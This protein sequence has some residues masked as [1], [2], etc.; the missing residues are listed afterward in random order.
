V[1]RYSTSTE[2]E[3]SSFLHPS[4]KLCKSLHAAASTT[5]SEQNDNNSAQRTFVAGGQ[6]REGVV[7]LVQEFVEPQVDL[8]NNLMSH[9]Y[10]QR[11]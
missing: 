9:N 1:I 3:R 5:S 6:A 11:Y 2:S 8:V 7:S 10:G 4:I